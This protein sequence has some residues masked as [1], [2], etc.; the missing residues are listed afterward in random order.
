MDIE[1]FPGQAAVTRVVIDVPA[2]PARVQL[3]L[4]NAKVLLIASALAHIPVSLLEAA[5]FSG[6][7]C[8]Q[9]ARA[10]GLDGGAWMDV[11]TPTEGRL[12]AGRAWDKVMGP[13]LNE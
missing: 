10:A 1:V 11:L 6:Y 7:C 5:G 12:D 8:D 9:L 13:L 3:N 4:S 2:T